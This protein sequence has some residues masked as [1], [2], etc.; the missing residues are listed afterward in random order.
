MSRAADWRGPASF[1]DP[2]FIVRHLEALVRIPSVN[3]DLVAGAAGE[4]EVARYLAQVCE[5]LG[6][7]TQIEMA[8]P[9]RPNVVAVLSGADPANGRSLMINGHT[10]TVGDAGMAAP[11]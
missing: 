3:P 1:V 6:M 8:A 11:F 7:R 9:R 2:D 4:T 5:G 10:D